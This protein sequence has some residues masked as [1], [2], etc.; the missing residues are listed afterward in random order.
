MS[1]GFVKVIL[2]Y[3]LEEYCSVQVLFD[4][5]CSYKNFKP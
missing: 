2:K 5:L 4:F 1:F 3:V